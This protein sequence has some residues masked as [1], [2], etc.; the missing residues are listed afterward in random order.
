MNRQR[1]LELS[2]PSSKA[3]SLSTGPSRRACVRAWEHFRKYGN[4]LDVYR[5]RARKTSVC[6]LLRK[7][8]ESEC[9]S[10][11]VGHSW[12]LQS[13]SLISAILALR[14][15]DAANFVGTSREV[16]RPC[17]SR[18]WCPVTSTSD[19]DW[20]PN[21]RSSCAISSITYAQSAAREFLSERRLL[22]FFF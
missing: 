4:A 9:V 14:F 12:T 8:G 1:D 6:P 20:S 21:S 13:S 2:T 7:K 22:H 10:R 19:D 11:L 15:C 16:H 5:A 18:R 17:L 3:P